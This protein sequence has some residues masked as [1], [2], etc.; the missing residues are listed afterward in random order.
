MKSIDILRNEPRQDARSLE[1]SQRIMCGIRTCP[2]D[3]WP[4]KG[5]SAPISLP[6]CGLVNELI[7]LDRVAT[8]PVAVMI[9]IGR[10]AGRA[11]DTG[12]RERNPGCALQ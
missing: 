2:S 11:A 3:S 4:A 5:R 10:Y 1:R 6:F 12:T 8:E 9:A 7:V